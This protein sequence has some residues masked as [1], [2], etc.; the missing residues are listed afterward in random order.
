MSA[1]TDLPK[2]P[3][4][5]LY[6]AGYMI[7]SGS[8][9]S[10]VP[11]MQT[12][13]KNPCHKSLNLHA[14]NGTII[15]TYGTRVDE[16]DIMGRRCKHR[17]IV[18]NVSQPILGTDFFSDGDGKDFVIDVAHRC[19]ID[20]ETFCATH[21]QFRKSPVHSITK[22]SWEISNI[23]DTSAR[24]TNLL[25][26]FPEIME[27][28]LGKVTVMAK[29]LHIDTGN[30][31]PVA[32]RCRNLH[33][34][35]KAAIEA[36]LRKW[37]EEGIIVRCNSEWASPIHAVKKS[38]GSWRVCGDFR[39]LNT[40]T[41]SDKYPLPSMRHF[42]DQLSGSS[43]FSKIDLRRAYQQVKID[44]KSQDKTAIITTI[45]LFKFRRMAFG[46]KNAGQCFQRNTHELLRDL[47]FL[48]VYMD[49]IIIGSS[50]SDEH[51][52]HLR[53]LFER[54]RET[55]LVINATKSIFGVAS[56]NFLGHHVDSNG[57][58]IPRE[59]ADAITRYP[60]PKTV[61][62]LERFMGIVAYFYRFIHHA[63]GRMSPLYKMKN[64]RTKKAFTANW[65]E[66]HDRAFGIAKVAVAKA[67][68]L[69]HPI[70]GATTELWCDASNI[71]VGAVLVQLQKGYWRPLAFWSKQLN[72]AQMNYS[73]TDRELLAVSYAVDHF[74]SHI[75]GQ[76]I[77]V[78]TDHLPLVGSI[79]K[80]ADTALPIPRRHLNRIAQF[81]DEVKHLS[82]DRNNLADAMSRIVLVRGK[83]DTWSSSDVKSESKQ[84]SLEVDDKLPADELDTSLDE[85][86]IDETFICR[87][88]QYRAHEQSNT[89][90]CQEDSSAISC[91]AIFAHNINDVP[92]KIPK[93]VEF[94]R[95]QETDVKLKAW[96]KRHRESDSP[97]HPK[98]TDVG[99]TSLWSD[100]SA[101]VIRIL[102]P[103]CLK[104]TVFDGMHNINHP[105]YKAG[106]SMLKRSYWWSGMGKDVSQWSRSCVACQLT[107]IHTHVK[108]PFEQLPPPT[109]RFSHIHVDLVGPLT[110]CEGKNMLLTVIDRWTSW[111]EAF[112]LSTTGEAASAQACAKLI[113]REWIPRFGVPDMVTSDRG[114]QFT[115]ELWTSM[116]R[117]MGIIRDTT[118]AY[119]PQ[120]NGKI[121]RWHRTLKNALRARL[122]GRHNWIA[123]L[124]WVMLGLRTTP[125]L[126]TGISPALLVMGQHPAL[127]GQLVIPRDDIVDHTAFS[128]RLARAMSAQVFS[129]NPWH[130]GEQSGRPVPQALVDASSVLVRRDRLQGS[131]EP[132]YDG[133]FKVIK[134]NKK[135]FTIRKNGHN[136]VISVDRLKPFYDK[137]V[138]N[139]TSHELEIKHERDILEWPLLPSRPKR[140]T[141]PP[142]RLGFVK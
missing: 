53:Q 27:T 51:Y 124:P 62:E 135:H 5:L 9:V 38:D 99:E 84:I 36:E 104:R 87:S 126:D 81:I 15:E 63:S 90:T 29:P 43:I 129:G 65:T 112:P 19:L 108:T 86:L 20:R 109:K 10:V 44:E 91:R 41:K 6:V 61:E 133:P 119:H 28:D 31:V 103:T 55:G 70:R 127:P 7:D 120:H 94:R 123:E 48:F 60:K 74:R 69:A 34:E 95:Y 39:R 40:V 16:F 79:R 8:V 50:S 14:A 121:E 3:K 125:N 139:V 138:T 67:T 107:K 141:N 85:A 11:P 131:L 12:E 106:Y 142:D 113:V 57:I 128:E 130:G 17:M 4:R 97:F 105:S 1:V 75:E 45:G 35:K 18:A 30:A 64:F 72:E 89:L 117:L 80:A 2:H 76:P 26:E 92:I 21:G 33:G 102:V 78:R 59:R 122:L 82:G 56:L 42:N 137:D 83:K 134:R 13:L 98:L 32:S 71:A 93:P 68:M 110:S 73:A 101:G 23:D 46:L 24:F 132:K 115:S 100:E 37:E 54:L 77:T 116:C 96:I 88:R 58:S 114:S 111:P 47:P 118:T 49:D 136:D 22:P 66:K 140:Q 52:D 25:S